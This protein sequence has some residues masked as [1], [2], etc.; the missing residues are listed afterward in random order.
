MGTKT[1][2]TNFDDIDGTTED[3]RAVPLSFDGTS[4]ETDLSMGERGQVERTP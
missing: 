2:T 4:V 3:V 1:V